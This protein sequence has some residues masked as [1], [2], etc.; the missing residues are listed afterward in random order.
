MTVTATEAALRAAIDKASLG[1]FRVHKD[2]L[3]PCQANR[4]I[5]EQVGADKLLDMTK[6]ES[7]EIA[8]LVCFNQL[9]KPVRFVPDIPAPV[10]EAEEE[11][12]PRFNDPSW[13]KEGVR[14]Y[15]KNQAERIA[16]DRRRI[17]AGSR[18]QR[19]L[20]APSIVLPP[21]IT[22]KVLVNSSRAELA[23]YYNQY[24]KQAVL[25]RIDGRS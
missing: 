12:A 11:E 10:V 5:L 2:D 21:E 16:P 25:D 22:R 23:G 6:P 19:E 4:Q 18:D 20:D 15:V 24:S 9:A 14:D 1:F 17:I 8:L 13:S 7:W 3:S